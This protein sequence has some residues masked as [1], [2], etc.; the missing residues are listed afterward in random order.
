MQ[1]YA[2]IR[3][4]ASGLRVIFESG[5]GSSCGAGGES[6]RQEGDRVGTDPPLPMLGMVCYR[7]RGESGGL[8]DRTCRAAPHAVSMD[9]LG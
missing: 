9:V 4:I 2:S 7:Q 3:R 5:S 6:G 8:E 1:P